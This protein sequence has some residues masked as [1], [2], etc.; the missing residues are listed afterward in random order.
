M[1][2]YVG[3]NGL[4]ELAFNWVIIFLKIVYIGVNINL[5]IQPKQINQI[6]SKV[7]DETQLIYH[8]LL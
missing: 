1:H 8:Q 3:C 7:L 4:T 2:V 6:L 5:V